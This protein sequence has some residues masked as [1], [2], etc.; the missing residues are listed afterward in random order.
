[1]R[2]T[3]VAG[4]RRLAGED[5]AQDGAEA[6]HVGALVEPL[7]LAAGLLRRHVRRR[8]HRLA[9]PRTLPGV[10]A[11][12]P[13]HAGRRRRLRRRPA[14]GLYL[15]QAPVHELH[16]AEGAD[17]HVGRLQVAVDHPLAVRVRHRLADRLEDGQEARKV[18][19]RDLPLLE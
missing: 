5:F 3:R 6:E 8:P 15:G 18:V 4:E 2:L 14:L 16:L 7:D 10:A 13:H 1:V 11:H 9:V 17:H 12:R 19:G